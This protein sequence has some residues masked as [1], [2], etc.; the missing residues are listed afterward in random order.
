M[1]IWSRDRSKL[2]KRRPEASE[3]NVLQVLDV[4]GPT[5]SVTMYH[6]A[7]AAAWSAR[8]G[9]RSWDRGEDSDDVFGSSWCCLKNFKSKT[10]T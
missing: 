2:V 7:Q 1:V 5:R 3:D 9:E 6:E 4:Y 10:L 8:R